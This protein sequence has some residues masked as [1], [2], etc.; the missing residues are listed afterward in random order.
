MKA[1]VTMKFLKLCAVLLAGAALVGCVQMPISYQPNMQNI[2]ALRA[3]N[4][5]PV[6]VGAF[7]LAAGKNPAI[8]KSVTARSGTFV[9]PNGDSFA[10]FL[11]EALT[12]ELKAAGKHDA[13]STTVIT[14]ALT[15]NSLEAP[16]G[17]G[18]GSLGARFTVTR[19]GVAAYQKDLVET[20]QWPSGFVGAE[21]IPTALNEYA[22]LYKKLFA[23]L[24]GDPDFRKAAAR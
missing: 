21:A 8:D 20:A 23:R 1:T 22:S 14:G 5:A 12:Q 3:S 19:G 7:V 24:F 4:I 13:Q 16:I 15:D 11:K 10:Q 9:S 6:N 17:T 18:K 2:E